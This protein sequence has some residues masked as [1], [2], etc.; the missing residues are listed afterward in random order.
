MDCKR[1]GGGVSEEEMREIGHRDS[2]FLGTISK[3]LELFKTQG[4]MSMSIWKIIPLVRVG[5]QCHI[6]QVEV[7]VTK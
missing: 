2:R 5:F 7:I 1:K 4:Y 6:S 3:D